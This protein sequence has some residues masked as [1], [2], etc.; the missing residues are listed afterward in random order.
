MEP[1]TLSAAY[2]FYCG[3]LLENAHSAEADITA[4]AEIL[5]AQLVRYQELEK[6]V[7]FLHEFTNMHKTVDLA[8]RMVYDQNKR[9]VF[10][11]GKHKGKL[12]EEVFA[13]EPSYFN[14]LMNGDF[15]SESKAAFKRIKENMQITK[16]EDLTSKLNALS[17]KFNSKT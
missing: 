4:T 7:D 3:K 8:G 9:A 5:E 16:G 13:A 15:A 11:F 2:K 14:W 10:N 1:R 6:N 17:N 12:V